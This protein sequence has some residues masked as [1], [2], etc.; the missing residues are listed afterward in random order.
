MAKM[1]IKMRPYFLVVFF[2]AGAAFFLVL[3]AGFSHFPQAISSHTPRDA[4]P[5][6]AGMGLDRI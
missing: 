1:A 4:G 2:F 3:L 5:L 6:H